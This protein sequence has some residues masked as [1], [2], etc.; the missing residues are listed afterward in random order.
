MTHRYF[1]HTREEIDLM[2]QRCGVATLDDLYAD[3]PAE[4]R[5]TQGYDLPQQM[6]EK[7]IRD[8]FHALGARNRTLTCFAGAGYYDHYQPAIVQSLISRSE[9]LTAYTPYQPEISQG[10]L[11]YIFE[12]QSM[13]A[14]L[15]GMDVSNASMYDGTTAT[16]EAMMMAV[17]HARKRRRVLISA[18]LSP[19]VRRVIDTYARYHGI[20]TDTIAED[21]AAGTTSRIDLEAKLAQGDVAG[22]ILATP[23][24][25]GIL[26]DYTGVAEMCHQ[27][28]ALLI[29]HTIPSALG[30]IRSPG[31]WGADIATGDGQSLGMP[32]SYGGPYLGFI[33]CKKA[34]IR[35]LPG[36]IVGATT[37]A[38][39]KRVF[40]LTLQAREQHIRRDKATSNICSNQGLM[41]L[42]ATIYLSVMG[43]DGLKSICEQSYAGAHTLRDRL[44]AT[45]VMEPTWPDSP[46]L[47]EFVMTVHTD[48]DDLIAA[49]VAQGILPGVKI[50]P[51][52]MLIAV[53]EMQTPA[54]M[55]LLV[56]LVAS[57]PKK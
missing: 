2:L 30:A 18:T 22:V 21:T 5:L 24:F 15:T 42:Y 36:R 8:Y 16:A 6:S 34:L 14:T 32:L 43:P 40:V 23:N 49:G 26:E 25:Y 37:D 45:G 9:F 3:V 48:V 20:V 28:K 11:Q 33:C 44:T 10:T 29:M 46:F 51:D 54:D 52:R 1:P 50:A 56:K 13:M 55:D 27:A 47:N 53:T 35:K 41:A 19:A 7:E 17:A 12:Y 31:S 38:D 39:G 4:L 57:S